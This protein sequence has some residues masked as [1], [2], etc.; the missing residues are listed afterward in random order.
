[1]RP[2]RQTACRDEVVDCSLDAVLPPAR[3]P[4]VVADERAARLDE[5]RVVLRSAITPS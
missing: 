3:D 2:Q 1:L 4:V 5:A